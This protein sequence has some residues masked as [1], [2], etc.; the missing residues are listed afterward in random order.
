MLSKT[1]KLLLIASN[2]L[3]LY[4]LYFYSMVLQLC[5]KMIFVNGLVLMLLFMTTYKNSEEK[6][7]IKSTPVLNSKFWNSFTRIIFHFWNWSLKVAARIN[8]KLLLKNVFLLLLNILKITCNQKILL[9]KVCFLKKNI[10]CGFLD[11]NSQWHHNAISNCNIDV[12]IPFRPMTLKK[13]WL[14]LAVPACWLTSMDSSKLRT[15]SISRDY[16]PLQI[17][18]VEL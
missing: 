14:F 16:F 8:I 3:N 11:S 4:H 5:S 10:C 13:S 7:N 17:M 1:F 18:I 9:L 2:S 6:R 15:V 12:T